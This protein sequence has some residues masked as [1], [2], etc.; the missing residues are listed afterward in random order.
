MGEFSIPG[1]IREIAAKVA[2][3]RGVELVHSEVAGTK[4]DSVV[5]IYI[6]KPDGVTLDDCGG[7]SSSVEDVLDAEDFIPGKYVLEVSSPGI[8]RELYTLADFEKFK[9]RLVKVKT[10]QEFA[11][12]KNFVG[13][14]TG[15]EDSEITIEDRTVGEVQ[16]PYETVTKANLKIDLDAE[17]KKR[18]G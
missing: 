9:G 3:D 17:F 12:Q 11:G 14:L 18:Q 13:S 5:R 16:F 1:R 10:S 2:E 8:E 6:D 15:V 7:F 4:R